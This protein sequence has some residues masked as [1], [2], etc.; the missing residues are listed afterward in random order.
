MRITT[1]KSWKWRTQI[2][3]VLFCLLT[4]VF[5]LAVISEFLPSYQEKVARGTAKP[6]LTT[7]VVV[8]WIG[9]LGLW[10]SFRWYYR[11][12]LKSK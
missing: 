11:L 7:N 2:A 12:L 9:S 5:I 8:F 6:M 3:F 10:L 4:C 1:E